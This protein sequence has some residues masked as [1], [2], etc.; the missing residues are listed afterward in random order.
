MRPKIAFFVFNS[1]NGDRRVDRQASLLAKNGYDVRIYCFLQPGLPTQESRHGYKLLRRDQRGAFNRFFDDEIMARLRPRKPA[2]TEAVTPQVAVP[3]DRPPV[4][5]CPEPPPRR[6]PIPAS[7]DDRRY[8][9][10]IRQINQIWAKEAIA[11]KPDLVQAHDCDALEAAARTARACGS[12]FVYDSHELWSDQPFITSQEGIEYWNRV[13][14]QYLGETDARLTVSVPFA[15]VLEERYGKPFIPLHNCQDYEVAPP[16]RRGTL[17]AR[18]GGRPVALYQGVYGL[19][20]GL[21]EL[22]ASAA[23]QEEVVIALRGY[24]DR[25]G[26]MRELARP[27]PHVVFLEP[28]ASSDIVASAAEADFGVIPFLPTCLNHYYNTPNKLFEF[29]MAGLP[30]ASADLPDL[31]R[32]IEGERIGLLFDPYSLSDI[33]RGLVELSRR[34]DLAEMG[35]RAHLACKERFNWATEGQKLL[36]CYASL[37]VSAGSGS[38]AAVPT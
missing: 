2:V 8:W 21:E 14:G 25:E 12:K 37:G 16:A 9:A 34:S 29:M 4:R 18:F 17:R 20:R 11:W 15:E 3:V 5:P 22:I 32:F 30:I 10:Y 35:Q 19:D 24:G 33:A 23:Y 31:R 13:E 7:E 36:A 1:G 27:Y 28:C 26:A 6:L 38:G